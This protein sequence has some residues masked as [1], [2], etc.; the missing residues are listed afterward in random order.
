[1][2]DLDLAG[3]APADPGPPD[4]VVR[5]GNAAYVLFTSGSTGPPKGVVVEHR[6]L[7]A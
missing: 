1:M 7:V 2:L 3:P 5:P 6:N 4:A